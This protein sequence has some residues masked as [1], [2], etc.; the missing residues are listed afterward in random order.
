MTSNYTF[1]K[2]FQISK[3]QRKKEQEEIF[4]SNPRVLAYCFLN[5][6]KEEGIFPACKKSRKNSL[7]FVSG[8]VWNRGNV[9]LIIDDIRVHRKFLINFSPIPF[10]QISES[11]HNIP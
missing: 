3:A 9:W 6:N 7:G 5:S 8:L 11:I 1:W 4:K 2:R 10:N